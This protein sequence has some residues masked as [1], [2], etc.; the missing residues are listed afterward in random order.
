[1][2]V[3]EIILKKLKT[4]YYGP[5]DYEIRQYYLQGF[6]EEPNPRVYGD[7][8]YLNY[9]NYPYLCLDMKLKDNT[10]EVHIGK[11][12]LYAGSCDSGIQDFDEKV[13]QLVCDKYGFIRTD[14][15]KNHFY[16]T[17]NSV[18]E[19]VIKTKVGQMLTA[20][21]TLYLLER[22]PDSIDL[23]LSDESYYYW[24][25]RDFTFGKIDIETVRD[26]LKNHDWVMNIEDI[27]NGF[28]VETVFVDSKGEPLK[29]SAY[30]SDYGVFLAT[31]H[32]Y[33]E[34]SK[35]E[36][37]DN[38]LSCFSCERCGYLG[39]EKVECKIE[40]EKELFFF[41][42]LIAVILIAENVPVFEEFM[43][44]YKNK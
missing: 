41:E 5:R 12:T 33:Q 43:K 32:N 2:N 6:Y 23:L 29:I 7:S 20:G 14:K 13:I 44:Q 26:Y 4:M 37:I 31:D 38:I 15:F 21:M 11:E 17:I 10:V 35:I 18:N 34:L 9:Q 3:G 25:R 24:V 28:D 40:Q 42:E 27:E 39:Y 19:S 30:S 8:L 22:K 36:N 16:T 1:M